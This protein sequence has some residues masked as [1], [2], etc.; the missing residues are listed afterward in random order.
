V[1]AVKAMRE[2]I[3]TGR[4]SMPANSCWPTSIARRPDKP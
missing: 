4:L 2:T 3:H 1:K